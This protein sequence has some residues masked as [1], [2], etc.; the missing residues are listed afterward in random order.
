[1]DT[2]DRQ[3]LSLLVRDARMSLKDLAAHTG[4]S[5]PTVSE[6]LARLRERGVVRAYTLDL[7]PSALGY[8]LQALVRVR[9]LPGCL[10]ATQD[11]IARMDEVIECDAVTGDD[12][13]VL[14]VVLRSM[15]HLDQVLG[16]LH[17]IA[18]TSSALVKSQPLPRRQAPLWPTGATPDPAPQA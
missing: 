6:R 13:F 1:M 2:L 7:E 12:C 18:Q 17:E 4:V 14:R 3:L 9:P 5:T 11:L 16:P 15:Q 10:R 8:T